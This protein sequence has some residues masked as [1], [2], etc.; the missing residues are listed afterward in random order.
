M[1]NSQQNI[2][3]FPNQDEIYTKKFQI[4]LKGKKFRENEILYE[5][6]EKVIGFYEEFVVILNRIKYIV[7]IC[8]K[9]LGLSY[10]LF[11]LD[12]IHFHERI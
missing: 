10:I 3:W 8:W 6:Q 7:T 5:N 12:L 2:L 4:L 9:T 1:L 11:K